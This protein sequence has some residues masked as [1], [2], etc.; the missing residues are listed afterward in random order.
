MEQA[1]WDFQI[2]HPVHENGA[3]RIGYT[4]VPPAGAAEERIAVD[5]RFPSAQIA[6]EEA[7]RLA[8]IHV[9]DLNGDTA[10]FEKPTEDEVPFGKNPRF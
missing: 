4:L 5:E 8:Q 9:A 1:K 2:E 3:W 10:A 6:I 7:T